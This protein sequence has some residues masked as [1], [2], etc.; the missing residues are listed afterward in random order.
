VHY[1]TFVGPEIISFGEMVAVITMVVVGGEATLM[2]PVVGAI[3]FTLLPEYLRVAAAYRML[4]FGGLLLLMVL[5]M[6]EGLIPFG[7]RMLALVPFRP[8]RSDARGS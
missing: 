1:I 8:R 7:R 3:V 4:I 6:P 2:G 5:L